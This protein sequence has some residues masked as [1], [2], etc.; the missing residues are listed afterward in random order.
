MKKLKLEVTKL[1][2]EVSLLRLQNNALSRAGTLT[3]DEYYEQ[4]INGMQ[5]K[6][7]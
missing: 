3:K 1:R 6:I 4:V 2:M 5:D 7:E